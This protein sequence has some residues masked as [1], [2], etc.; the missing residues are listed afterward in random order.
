MKGLMR[1][2]FKHGEN[3]LLFL[4]E[5]NL[6]KLDAVA[7]VQLVYVY[8]DHDHHYIDVMDKKMSAVDTMYEMGL[9]S[10][11]YMQVVECYDNS[12]YLDHFNEILL[13]NGKKPVDKVSD[14]IVT[15][16]ST[17]GDLHE[18]QMIHVNDLKALAQI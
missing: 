4:R 8:F 1:M 17:E 10:F 5:Y 2:S 3:A 7:E 15:C 18:L 14:I 16:V 6:E 11:P 13:K 9:P 12:V